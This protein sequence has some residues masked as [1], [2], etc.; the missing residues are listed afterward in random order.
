LVY[1]KVVIIGS[2]YTSD[3]YKSRFLI[4]LHFFFHE[5]TIVDKSLQMPIIHNSAVM[6]GS[7]S[8]WDS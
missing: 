6:T 8:D 3:L 1:T 7:V 2:H 5:L 4:G